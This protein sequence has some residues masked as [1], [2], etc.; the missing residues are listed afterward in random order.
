MKKVR[1]AFRPLLDMQRR[2]TV[3]EARLAQQAE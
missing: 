2:L 3:L 1:E